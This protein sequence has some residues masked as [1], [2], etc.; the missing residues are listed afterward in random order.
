MI[1][2]S[3]DLESFIHLHPK[4][5]EN[6]VYVASKELEGGS[7]QAFVDIAPKKRNN[8]VQPNDFQVGEE[9]QPSPLVSLSASEDRTQGI[10]GKT[11]TL[12]TEGLSTNGPTTLDFYLHG[13]D[14]EPYLG[15]LGHVVILDED[16]ETFIHVHPTSDNGTNFETHIDHPGLYKVWAEFKYEDD[17]LITFAFII[18]VEE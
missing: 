12:E 7:Y 5:V 10:D 3:N 14:P 1:I 17:G 8:V 13:E 11:A 6:G 16:A 9:D 4:R 15:A 2:V 18:Q